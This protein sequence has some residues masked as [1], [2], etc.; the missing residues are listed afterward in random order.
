MNRNEI[1]EA[2]EKAIGELERTGDIN[3]ENVFSALVTLNR[4]IGRLEVAASLDDRI[5]VI[6]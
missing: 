1:I 6:A 5:E 3:G 4:L 2:V